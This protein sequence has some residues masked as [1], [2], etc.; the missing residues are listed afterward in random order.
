MPTA[1]PLALDAQGTPH[2]REQPGVLSKT[3]GLDLVRPKGKQTRQIAPPI[4]HVRSDGGFDMFCGWHGTALGE[5]NLRIAAAHGDFFGI[6]DLSPSFTR[7]VVCTGG[8][9]A[10]LV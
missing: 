8:A 6:A 7:P 2:A 10:S 1:S 4:V 5:P 9:S 3:R